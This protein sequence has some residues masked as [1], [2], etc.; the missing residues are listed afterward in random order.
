MKF[1]SS[2]D[3]TDRHWEK[4]GFIQT[5]INIHSDLK[6]LC[7]SSGCDITVV[8]L[9][10]AT[11]GFHLIATLQIAN[12]CWKYLK[13][14]FALFTTFR[15]LHEHAT[16][17]FYLLTQDLSIIFRRRLIN[18]SL[19]LPLRCVAPILLKNHHWKF[20]IIPKGSTSVQL[21]PLCPPRDRS[22]LFATLHSNSPY[23]DPDISILARVNAPRNAQKCECCQT[24][25]HAC[26][27]NSDPC[28][29]ARLNQKSFE[30]QST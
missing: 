10:V 23:G 16:I 24:N 30:R 8:C 12:E 29:I 1:V 6:I 15:A 3:K 5:T 22:P 9:W 20:T 11:S 28:P 26:Y 19:S 4:G 18:W 27:E 14:S 21:L 2:I 13:R 7:V 17:M 25:K